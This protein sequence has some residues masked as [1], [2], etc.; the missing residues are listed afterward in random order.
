MRFDS[1]VAGFS[2][3]A[4]T[5][6]LMRFVPAGADWF[7]L[8]GISG[9][10]AL[11]VIPYNGRLDARIGVYAL[12]H[13]LLLLLVALQICSPQLSLLIGV[14]LYA[15]RWGYTKFLF[16]T[17]FSEISAVASA[18]DFVTSTVNW[19]TQEQIDFT[20]LALLASLINGRPGA[21]RVAGA[22]C[23]AITLSYAADVIGTTWIAQT[24]PLALGFSV[25][26]LLTRANS[27]QSETPE[28]AEAVRLSIFAAVLLI[29]W[30][31]LP[32]WT[33]KHLSV[34]L[35]TGG[36]DAFE[37]KFFDNYQSALNFSGI[38]ST[39]IGNL[40]EAP[41]GAT[42]ILPWVTQ[43][44]PNE[45]H[46]KNAI[47]SRALH[48]VFLGEHTNLGGVRDRINS[49]T[50][51]S[52]LADDLTVPMGNTDHIGISKGAQLL[53]LQAS[54]VFNRGA[55]VKTEAT[56]RVFLRGRAW[57]TE[58]N[59]NIWM[60]LGDYIWEKGDR[61]G[62][63][64]VGVT[65]QVQKSRVSVLGDN[66]TFVAQ[67]LIA[68]PLGA[69]RL[70][71]AASGYPQMLSDILLFALSFFASFSL[72]RLGLVTVASLLLVAVIIALSETSGKW[73]FA[74]VGQSGFDPRNFN[75]KLLKIPELIN[76]FLV[77]RETRSIEGSYE[78][79]ADQQVTFLT[80]NQSVE[81][82]GQ[83]VLSDCQR[84][85]SVWSKDSKV[86]LMDA[87]SCRATGNIKTLIGSNGFGSVFVIES[88]S[89][90]HIVIL[91]K[92]FLSTESPEK[93][94]SF[95]KGLLSDPDK[96]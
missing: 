72:K 21:L 81:I 88:P 55:S 56:D 89:R 30:M 95:I 75:E 11:L 9:H 57:W 52:V 92:K 37:S 8:F 48:L 96:K 70:L 43:A 71:L 14:A 83:L 68:N 5:Y 10:L 34:L 32:P 20:L 26:P 2:V 4:L 54:T 73:R 91:D 65:F 74:N 59:R 51:R 15:G 13:A 79:V 25:F 46:I 35:P 12:T 27:G 44:L 23:T 86:Y 41:E 24:V 19:L 16:I 22:S 31:S 29:A 61:R 17:V 28:R 1:S 49:L 63:I 40:S 67:Q 7:F 58:P 62:S 90:T 69:K 6:G 42:V 36:S 93:N 82:D 18:T 60:W 76:N 33:V 66:S 85:G 38:S 84:L 47:G 39:V 3:A 50:G 64:P 80:V 94:V 77:K 78:A 87:Q 45:E 53:P